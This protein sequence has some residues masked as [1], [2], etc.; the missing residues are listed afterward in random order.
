MGNAY[1]LRA[2][3]KK[4]FL[5]EKRKSYCRPHFNTVCPNDANNMELEIFCKCAPF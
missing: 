3:F 5:I 2:I 1:G 4:E